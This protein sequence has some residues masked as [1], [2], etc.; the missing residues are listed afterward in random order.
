MP[1]ACTLRRNAPAVRSAECL[2]SALSAMGS[3]TASHSGRSFCPLG[4]LC[5]K[6]ATREQPTTLQTGLPSV[7]NDTASQRTFWQCTGLAL[8]SLG[9][10]ST[11]P[12]RYLAAHERLGLSVRRHR[13]TMQDCTQCRQ[14]IEST[15]LSLTICTCDMGHK[16]RTRCFLA[17]S[18]RSFT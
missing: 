13:A 1:S 12:A 10:A 17:L 7:S 3:S 6:K 8:A 4:A 16:I 15:V 5:F 9:R 11:T 18:H 2:Q 14:H